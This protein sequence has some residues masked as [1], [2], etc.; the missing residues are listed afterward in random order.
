MDPNPFQPTNR[1]GYSDEQVLD[2]LRSGNDRSHLVL[3]WFFGQARTY[4]LG[5]LQKKYPGLDPA[6]WD[7]IFANT[8]LKLI[9]RIRKGLQL[10]EGT[11]L[12]TYYTSV[13]GF[14]A[15]DFVADRK[16]TTHEAVVEDQAQQNPEIVG[17][18]EARERAQRIQEW[19]QQIIG[20][21]EQVKV[22][23][24]QAKGY[25]F[26]EIVDLTNYHSEGACR[27]AALKGKNKMGAYLSEHPAAAK[28]LKAL[29]QQE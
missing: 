28:K 21:D 29:L 9:T 14:A 13:A 18:M 26:K 17:K 23:L 3:K 15:L 16:G 5:Y 4:T 27:N 19:L 2:A 25:S 11:R 10:A 12:T 6:E 20:H 8:N 7:V 22:L 1:K 24:L